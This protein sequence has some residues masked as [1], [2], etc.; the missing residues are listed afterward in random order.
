MES[1]TLKHSLNVD[2][3]TGN[4]NASESEMISPN[5]N[6]ILFNNFRGNE[7]FTHTLGESDS[8]VICI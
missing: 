5:E 7:V 6:Y 8:G 4:I 1:A 2:L 3:D